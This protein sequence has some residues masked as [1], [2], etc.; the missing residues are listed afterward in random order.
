MTAKQRK[1]KRARRIRQQVK[2]AKERR[3]VRCARCGRL[4]DNRRS[5]LAARSG[6]YA[7]WICFDCF[8]GGMGDAH[9][10]FE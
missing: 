2:D 3:T 10:S 9:E 8:R 5:I 4:F 7:A 1:K 6:G